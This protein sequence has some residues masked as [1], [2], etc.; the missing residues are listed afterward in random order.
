[1]TSPQSEKKF[2]ILFSL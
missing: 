2:S 1:V